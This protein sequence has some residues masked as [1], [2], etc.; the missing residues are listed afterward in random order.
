MKSLYLFFLVSFLSTTFLCAQ[1]N[2]EQTI[3]ENYSS[4]SHSKN[5]DP[6]DT[7]SASEAEL[8]LYEVVTFKGKIISTFYADF[9][10]GR[11]TFLNM[12]KLFPNNPVVLVRK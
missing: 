8:K 2:L 5:S 10:A 12:D 3:K 6:V 11:P 1:S 4:G 9:E 7:L